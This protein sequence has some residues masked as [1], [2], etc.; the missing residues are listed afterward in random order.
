MSLR[1]SLGAGRGRLIQQML[2]E[3]T[4][5][6]GVACL[7]GVMF[8][9]IA[10]PAVVGMLRSAD[11]PVLLDLRV[12]WRFVAFISGMTLLSGALLGLAPALRASSVAPMVALKATGGRMSS[13]ARA[14]RP[15]VVIQVAFSLIVLFVGGLL[16][17][18]FVTL[19]S[20]NP[21]FA[22][23]DVLI[24]SLEAVNA[25][26]RL[27][28]GPRCCRFWIGFVMS[29]VSLPSARPSSACS[30]GL[31]GTT[32]QCPALPARRSK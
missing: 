6:A 13:R 2:I 14:M 15:F 28:T 24:V 3:S 8:A 11:D 17:R 21:G 7:I 29:L 20:V 16:V 26:S 25:S 9:T 27:S 1:L 18:S 30:A 22:L 19:S 32:S 4:I 5:V 12:D 31:G 23:S 10:A